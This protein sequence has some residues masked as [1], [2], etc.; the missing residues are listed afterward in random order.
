MSGETTVSL[1]LGPDRD[2]SEAIRPALVAVHEFGGVLALDTAMV[3]RLAI[4]A[5]E[6]LMNLAD[7]AAF[8]ANVDVTMRLWRDDESEPAGIWIA[9]E[10][11]G[12]PFD[13]RS[14]GAIEGPNAERGG[15]VGLALIRAWA[16]VVD[17]RREGGRNRLELRML[18][19]D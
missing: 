15:G 18:G 12:P 11:D 8:E 6:A 7:H 10:D 5:E 17:Y 9:V 13:P 14:A 19:R 1:C 4:V 2:T 3:M 16:N